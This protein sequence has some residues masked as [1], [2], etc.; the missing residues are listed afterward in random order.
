MD[1]LLRIFI[2]IMADLHCRVRSCVRQ[3]YHG[4]DR[5]GIDRTTVLPFLGV[6]KSPDG[7][8]S[9][10]GI[11]KLAMITDP[12]SR[13]ITLE[14]SNLIGITFWWS[15]EIKGQM[16]HGQSGCGAGSVEQ[17]RWSVSM[18]LVLFTILTVEIVRKTKKMTRIGLR[19]ISTSGENNRYQCSNER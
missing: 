16:C 14:L 3:F 12:D 15:V 6:K 11:R 5:L 13:K 19:D 1:S 9:A 17:T 4:A 7:F 10:V 8:G 18:C 2:E